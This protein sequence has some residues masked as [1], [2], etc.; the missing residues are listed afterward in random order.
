MPTTK[1]TKEASSFRDPSGSIY[2]QGSKVYRQVNKIYKDNLDLLFK[3]GLYDLLVKNEYLLFHKKILKKI[4]KSANAYAVFE[5]IKLPFISYP[6]EW[7][8]SQLKDAALLTLNIQ[9]EALKKGM[10]L[11]DASAYNIQF[12][13]GKPIFIDFLSFEK[14]QEGSP[15]VAY[16]QF[17]QHFL[18]PLLLM[19][20]VDIRLQSLLRT[21]IDGI[22]L[23]L[24]SKLLPK[25]SYLALSILSHIHFHSRQQKKYEGYHQNIK[26]KYS[27]SKF[28]LE[29]IVN[30]LKSSISNIDYKDA[31]T[32]WGEYYTF[33][34]YSNQAFKNKKQLIK[35]YL[36]KVKPKTVL[37][38]GANNGEFSR[39]ASDK[40]I[41]TISADIDPVAVEKNYQIVK[42]KKEKNILPLLLDIT[43]P[44]PSIGWANSE[45][46]SIT[47]RGEA[48][49]IMAL[50]LIHHLAISNNLPFEKI[51]EYLSKLTK[52]LIIEFV[53]KE[54]SQVQKLLSSRDDIF[55]KYTKKDFE[56]SFSKK[57]KLI[58][59]ESVKGSLRT[60]YLMETK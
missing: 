14:Y 10:S 17:C 15:W 32:E 9:S 51:S 30:S 39:L 22:P 48:D 59:K 26:N 45:R 60:L 12:Y 20:K 37:D 42:K 25:K 7:S 23:D 38:L 19:S 5:T 21:N 2:Y 43:N 40:G 16:K 6:Y 47:N 35:K 13:Q 24:A 41:F 46:S 49:L 27:I 33:T 11:K 1:K 58:K 8:F 36:N 53:P 54:D 44:S 18:S 28:A 52:Y 3:S 57:F 31:K 56:K 55:D 50:A 34:N 4:P 29:G